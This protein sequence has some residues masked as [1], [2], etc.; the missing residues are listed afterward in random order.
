MLIK[1]A[2]LKKKGYLLIDT[3]STANFWY[4]YLCA[5]IATSRGL[6]YIPILHGGELPARFRKSEKKTSFILR[7][8]YCNVAPS[9]YLYD[10]FKNKGFKNLKQIANPVDIDCYK[11]KERSRLSPRL[12]W[13]RSFAKI[14]NPMMALEVVQELQKGFPGVHLC[15]VGPEKD[16]SLAACKAFAEAR[17]LPVTFTGKLEKTDWVEL[18]TEY[19]IFINTTHF[20]NMPVSVI[21]AMALGLPV[22]S[23]RVGG[24]PFLLEDGEN[25]LLVDDASVEQMVSAIQGLLEDV[26]LPATLASHA[27]NKAETFD[28]QIIK[29]AWLTLLS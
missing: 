20:D 14:Y 28:W 21:E 22:V 1:T 15:M 17:K 11:Y 19:D 29:E 16:G 2:F 13:V 9:G 18:S 25:A 27:R 10:F 24:I 3:Y 7:N 12:L 5:K 8:A 26:E 4:A 6:R 23:T